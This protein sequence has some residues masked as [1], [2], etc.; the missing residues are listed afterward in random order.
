MPGNPLGLASSALT[1]VK[2]PTDAWQGPSLPDGSRSML[3]HP[4][5]P[6]GL[7]DSSVPKGSPLGRKVLGGGAA[8]S[9]VLVI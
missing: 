4:Y 7:P 3:S 2:T 8:L 5:P 1:W 9:S 6:E